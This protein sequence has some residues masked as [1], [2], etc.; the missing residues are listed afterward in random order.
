MSLTVQQLLA[1]AKRL[2][3]RLRDHDASADN[4]ISNAQEVL[5]A[6]DAMRQ[7]QEDIDNLNSIAHNR[8]RAQ[9]VLG[10]YLVCQR[11]RSVKQK[12]TLK[13]F[14]LLSKNTQKIYHL[15]DFQ[16]FN[17]KTGIYDSYNMKIKS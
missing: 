3:G 15:Y 4:V 9:L 2:S 10:K 13:G 6:V 16:E 17:K 11:R 14:S 5:K 1:D 12:K 8:P 7:Y